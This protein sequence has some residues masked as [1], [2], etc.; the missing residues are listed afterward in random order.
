[1]ATGGQAHWI[2]KGVAGVDAHVPHLTLLGLYHMWHDTADK[3]KGA[4]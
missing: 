1:M 4:L 2:L 3:K